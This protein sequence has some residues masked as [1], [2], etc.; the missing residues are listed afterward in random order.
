[1]EVLLPDIHWVI[2]I[3]ACCFMLLDIITGFIQ[4]VINKCVDSKI[5]KRGLL[6]KC[7]FILAIVFGC[8]CEY[9]MAYIDLGFYMPIQDVVCA[10]IMLTEIVSILENLSKISP[11]LAS[12][13]FM[14][15]FSRKDK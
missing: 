7:G 1:M 4:A 8:L 2:I 12:S 6:H 11:D 13:K 15:I 10:Y 3:I 5:M 9:S 14:N